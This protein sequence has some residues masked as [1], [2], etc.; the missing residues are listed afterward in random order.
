MSSSLPIEIAST[1]QSASIR[2][3]PSPHHDLNPP[4]IA[5]SKIPVSVHQASESS[6]DKYA[7]DDDD[8]DEG[9]V[10]DDEE[11]IPY[12]VLKPL[13]RRPSF[14]PLPDLR[15]EQSYLA[16]IAGADTRWKVIYITV[17]DQVMLPLLQGMVWT[18]ALQ[19]WKYWNRNAKLHGESIGARA[20]RWWYK[21]NNWKLPEFRGIGRN[22]KLADKMG[23][24]YQNQSPSAGD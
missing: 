1:I 2:H 3:E 23:D 9:I 18:L 14:G 21:T 16:S 11:D 24:Y 12:D 17:R 20:R 22:Q 15:F 8:D 13:P 6:L 5:S 7:Y 10:E 4:S 19:G